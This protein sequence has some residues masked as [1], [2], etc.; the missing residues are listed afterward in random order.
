MWILA[1]V[2]IEMTIVNGYK[3]FKSPNRLLL[4][5][6]AKFKQQRKAHAPLIKL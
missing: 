2:Q 1:N 5:L 6:A 4:A 3:K